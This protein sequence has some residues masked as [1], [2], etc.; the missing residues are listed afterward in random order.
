M[1]SRRELP[2]VD[3]I[4][5]AAQLISSA[6]SIALVQ[7]R[8]GGIPWFDVGH[9]DPWNHIEAA[10]ALTVC[11]FDE[12]AD[13]AYSWLAAHQLPDG[14]WFN[15]Y[16][17]SG[18]ESTRL[19]TNVCAYVAAGAW[20]R[21]L[22]SGDRDR[23]A[24]DFEIVERALGFVLSFVRDDGLIPWSIDSSG[25]VE[26]TSL[27]TGS[28]SVVLSFRCAINAAEALTVAR[29]DWEKALSAL[30][31]HV[32]EGGERF[33]TK[34]EYAM[35]W[36]YPVLGGTLPAARALALI[37]ATWNR[38]VLD[39][40]GVRCVATSDWVTAAETAEC[41]VACDLAG[42][43]DRALALLADIQALRQPDGSYVTGVVHPGRNTFP[44]NERT[45]YSAAA[46][47]LAAD[48]LAPSARPDSL[49]RSID[50]LF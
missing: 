18:V 33:A 25:R 47:I 24:A 22:L 12:E 17:P 43:T 28:A 8:D 38:F 16:S 35:D 11:G 10:M 31:P 49:W 39:G 6:Q 32:A 5:C 37:E 9:L 20:H 7:R 4:L 29:P 27:R 30:I 45:T 15:Y 13:R 44:R 42:S 46:M 40:L 34:R 19:D 26:S 14:S 1:T 48:H 2:E 36:Y 3:G 23:L 41:A 21:Y 50:P